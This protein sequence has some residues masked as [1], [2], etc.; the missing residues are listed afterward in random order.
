MVTR[1]D[2]VVS[3]AATR[4]PRHPVER[5]STMPTITSEGCYVYSRPAPITFSTVPLTEVTGDAMTD[6]LSRCRAAARLNMRGDNYSDAERDDCTAKV[7]SDVLTHREAAP[8]CYC[9]GPAAS[10]FRQTGPAAGMIPDTYGPV[11]VRHARTVPAA[12]RI[13]P[14]EYQVSEVSFTTLSG[15]AS[16]YRRTIDRDRK[17]EKDESKRNAESVRFS[18]DLASVVIDGDSGRL[19]FL[20]ADQS[21]T[22]AREMLDAVGVRPLRKGDLNA[23]VLAYVAA[24]AST[25]LALDVPNPAERAGAEIGLTEQQVKDATRRAGKRIVPP[26]RPVPSSPK[27]GTGK[28]ARIGRNPARI[29]WTDLLHL[30]DTSRAVKASK[31]R[32][33]SANIG[34]RAAGWRTAPDVDAPIVETAIPAADVAPT[35]VAQWVAAPPMPSAD[36]PGQTIRPRS[37]PRGTAL[38]MQ[39]ATTLRHQQRATRTDQERTEARLSVGLSADRPTIGG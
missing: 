22:L 36:D 16:N 10:R 30:P 34:E 8:R 27:V 35:D 5:D 6:L 28:A 19:R 37:I 13:L 17:R 11:C 20:T 12:R 4:R 31:S 14:R 25:L 29:E 39:R 9:G 15:M 26:G 23:Y 32:T 7:L 3:G 24:R 1:T 21:A 33:D 38:R 2:T 18:P